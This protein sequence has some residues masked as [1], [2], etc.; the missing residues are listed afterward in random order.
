MQDGTTT[1]APT[2]ATHTVGPPRRYS[3]TLRWG[4]FDALFHGS[5]DTARGKQERMMALGYFHDEVDGDEGPITRRCWQYMSEEMAHQAGAAIADLPAHVREQLKTIVQ[6]DDDSRAHEPDPLQPMR[7]M[8]PGSWCITDAAQLGNPLT[9]HRKDA[10]DDAW[11]DN[12]GLGRLPLLVEVKDRDTDRPARNVKI[13][14]E[15]VEPFATADDQKAYLQTISNQTERSSN[16]RAYITGLLERDAALPFGFNCTTARAGRKPADV[17]GTLIASGHV[18]G[19]PHRATTDGRPNAFSMVASTDDQGLTGVVLRPGRTAGDCYKLKVYVL[20][21]AA[22]RDAE[23]EKTTGLMTVWRSQR[24]SKIYI[25]PPQGAFAGSPPLAARLQGALGTITTATVVSELKKAFHDTI[26]DKDAATPVNLTA[27]TYRAAILAAKTNVDNPRNYDLDALI[28]TSFASPYTFWLND[29]ATYNAN[30]AAGKRRLDLTRPASWDH[31]KDIIRDLR[32]GFMQHLTDRAVPGVM[33]VRGEV[34]DSYSYW[35]N[36][37]KPANL[38][39]ATTSGVA[40]IMRGCYVW[41]PNAIYTS[42]MPY[43]VTIN[44]LH[45]M[46]HVLFL[47]HHYTSGSGATASGGFSANHD[48]Q[49]DCIMGYMALT[50]NDFCG[51]CL[52]KL[53]GWDE[54]KF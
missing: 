39:P 40:T 18:H 32:D 43:P 45:E 6:K 27:A 49:D 4:N 14:F 53:R 13:C 10:E 2:G 21:A 17:D 35:A 9:A 52:L 12:L 3:I 19:F 47:R 50:T 28:N 23:A 26:I 34:G 15:Y 11:N 25:K 22:P 31:M 54:S 36:P 37:N 1:P 41:Y 5:L 29:D 46:G 51:K 42:N 16:P 20:E 44:T 8:F 38:R 30:R 33:V 48:A 24:V 7:I